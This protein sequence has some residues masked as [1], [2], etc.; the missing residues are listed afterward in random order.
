MNEIP[1][2]SHTRKE[3]TNNP[4]EAPCRKKQRLSPLTVVSSALDRAEG[5]HHWRARNLLS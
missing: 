2:L 4:G 3:E 5:E 1:Q